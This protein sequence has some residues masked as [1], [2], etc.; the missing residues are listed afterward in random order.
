M[1]IGKFKSF[2][3]ALLMLF[4]FA[5]IL[6]PLHAIAD[7]CPCCGQSYGAAAPE[8][9]ARV[10]A[11][12]AEHESL[13]CSSSD[14]SSGG[15]SGSYQQPSIDWGK[16]EIESKRLEQDSKRMKEEAEEETKRHE[17]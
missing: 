6:F 3:G 12:R 1:I 2:L 16:K 10:Y 4:L 9:E 15:S 17:E 7:S 11:L 8:D 13:C 5:V 14:G